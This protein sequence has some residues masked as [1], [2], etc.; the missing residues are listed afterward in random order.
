MDSLRNEKLVSIDESPLL[1]F[2]I[3]LATV[4]IK[5]K[6]IN[7]EL[8]EEKKE[9]KEEEVAPVLKKKITV[10]DVVRDPAFETKS[11]KHAPPPELT[12]LHF[13]CE[14][15]DMAHVMAS[16]TNAL[17]SDLMHA[18]LEHLYR[19]PGPPL[20]AKRRALIQAL[21]RASTGDRSGL[22]LSS[23]LLPCPF[24]ANRT[25]GGFDV[26][27]IKVMDSA[28]APVFVG[29]WWAADGGEG[30]EG[31]KKEVIREEGEEEMEWD[32]VLLEEAE[33]EE[34]KGKRREKRK[35]V[36]CSVIY[37]KEDM[38]K[39]DMVLRL[40]RWMNDIWKRAGIPI[41]LLTY[42]VNTVG[43]E[44]AC[45]QV[46]SGAC[47]LYEMTEKTKSATSILAHLIKHNVHEAL[48]A[49]TRFI[50]SLAGWNVAAALLGVC[51]RHLDNIMIAEDGTFFQIDFGWLIHGPKIMEPRTR[52]DQ[53]MVEALG[54]EKAAEYTAYLELCRDAAFAVRPHLPTFYRMLSWLCTCEPPLKNNWSLT[55]ADLDHE[56]CQ[57][58][59]PGHADEPVAEIYKRWMKMDDGLLTGAAVSVWDWTHR[60]KRQGGLFCSLFG[61][62]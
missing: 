27:H 10:L 3:H 34:E 28:A 45:V 36:D 19:I 18:F 38:R 39:D 54:G 32:D 55:L 41:H 25:I 51:D 58:F 43:V 9:K 2:L 60:V 11:E 40:V 52:M 46:V 35:A 31:E 13:R 6:P 29:C 49:Q 12:P 24:D 47:T 20:W 56:L 37:K 57:R 50:R 62:K 61:R 1:K 21:E 4:I 15:L 5:P 44:R 59:L 53:F 33:E 14:M 7:K 48:E 16:S 17:I 42:R 8:K 23:T 26:H 30:K 22:A